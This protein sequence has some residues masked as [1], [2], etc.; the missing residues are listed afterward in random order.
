MINILCLS[1]GRKIN[2]D[3]INVDFLPAPNSLIG[4]IKSITD[5]DRLYRANDK[6]YF[7]YQK[8]VLGNLTG[9]N[10]LFSDQCSIIHPE[11]IS[12]ITQKNFIKLLTAVDDPIST[13]SK[14]I[15]SGWAYDGIVYVSPSYDNNY[16]M[17]E[18]L[19]KSTNRPSFFLPHCRITD[20][21]EQNGDINIGYS[22]SLTNRNLVSYY[23]G[24]YY[25]EKA[26]RLAE[27]KRGL[28]N[29]FMIY[30]DWSFKGFRGYMR[31][32]KNKSSIS[33]VV[34][35]IT[36]FEYRKIAL[37][38]KVCI[39]LHYN[40]DRETG[41]QRLYQAISYG[42][43]VITD[44]GFKNSIGKIFENGKEILIYKSIAEAIEMTMEV[45]HKP[46][47]FESIRISGINRLKKNYL[48][49]NYYKS[50]VDI[51]EKIQNCN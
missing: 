4:R 6:E 5:L 7:D 31:K 34:R 14:T 51:Y 33:Q 22:N 48:L 36:D 30:G 27:L 16:S 13:Y 17:Q 46:S 18:L 19:E 47:E 50:L 11:V 44:G 9:I 10:I 38:T 24:G 15:P 41:N 26:D 29:D 2:Y 1:P 42:N 32:L 28:N 21:A 20:V 40:I 49:A 39:N 45:M 12:N 35:P 23:V 37:N 25:E 8:K 3:G 43:L